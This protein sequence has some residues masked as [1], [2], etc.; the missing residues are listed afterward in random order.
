MQRF[1]F[2]IKIMVKKENRNAL[3]M[4]IYG[5]TKEVAPE[6]KIVMASLIFLARHLSRSKAH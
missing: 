6:T 1:Q 3:R 5:G 4:N 2:Q